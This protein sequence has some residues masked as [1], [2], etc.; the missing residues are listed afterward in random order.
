MKKNIAYMLLVSMII[1]GCGESDYG[2]KS[3][4]TTGNQSPLI[5][6]KSSYNIPE[7]QKEAF[8]IKATDKTLVSYFIAGED[9]ADLHVDILTG[10]VVFRDKT[11]FE[12]KSIYKITVVVQDS[13]NNR[14]E[15][16]ITLNI[17][18]ID[19]TTV[20][21]IIK[22]DSEDSFTEAE[23]Q[24]AFVTVWKT[25]NEGVSNDNQI[26]IPTI[27]DGYNY[28]VDWGDGTMTTGITGDITHTYA[29]KGIY[30]TDLYYKRNI[31]GKN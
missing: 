29:N 17:T 7:N 24:K 20:P 8:E 5:D 11:D 12:T 3:S 9:A 22:T 13:V 31:Y 2:S 10:E 6:A 16:N 23:S 15:Q 25:D 30:N 27:G 4:F 14:A 18:D 26:K 21:V 1:Q 19:E 28:R